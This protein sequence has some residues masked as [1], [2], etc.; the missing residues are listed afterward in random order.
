MLHDMT[1]AFDKNHAV[2]CNRSGEGSDGRERC[3]SKMH[4][5]TLTQLAL[6]APTA[7]GFQGLPDH[8][9]ESSRLFD[10]QEKAQAVIHEESLSQVLVLCTGSVKLTGFSNDARLFGYRPQSGF[11]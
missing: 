7:N 2:V 9:F 6:S 10:P 11:P 8:L 5:L 4:K 1:E 3:R